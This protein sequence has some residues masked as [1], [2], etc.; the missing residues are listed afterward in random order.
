MSS[1]LS[2]YN[3]PKAPPSKFFDVLTGAYSDSFVISGNTYDMPIPFV[4]ANQVLD[5]NVN[6]SPDVQ[7]FVDGGNT[8]STA[9]NF[10]AKMMGG[11]SLVDALG[12]NMIAWLKNRIE[13]EE[14][15]GSEYTGPLNLYV[16]PFMT[17]I[18]L[19]A[20]QQGISPLND[21]SVYGITTEAPT[22]SEYIGGNFENNYYTAWVFKSP[23]TIQYV[24]VSGEFKYLTMTS[25]FTA[26]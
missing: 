9:V 5:I 17:K 1:V 26:N 24:G 4:V 13:N 2:Y 15:L 25:Q 19:A 8:P 18:Q 14:S 21:E 3:K 22:S 6:Q 16:K 23:I 12:P 10:Q 11:S 7:T 20:P